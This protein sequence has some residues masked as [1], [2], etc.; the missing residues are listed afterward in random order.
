M[1]CRGTGTQVALRL[2]VHTFV[3]LARVQAEHAPYHGHAAGETIRDHD[4]ALG[5]VLQALLVSGLGP[6]VAATGSG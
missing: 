4:L 3:K 6:R 5:Y 1:R 2:L